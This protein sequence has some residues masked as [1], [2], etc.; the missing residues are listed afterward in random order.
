MIH[1]NKMCFFDFPYLIEALLVDKYYQ[2]LSRFTCEPNC[3]L[4]SNLI[5]SSF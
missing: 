5:I 2:L 1:Y 3:L 4:D